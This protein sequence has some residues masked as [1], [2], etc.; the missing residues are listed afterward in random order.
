MYIL[1]RIL[2]VYCT[3]TDAHTHTIYD[4]Y[5]GEKQLWKHHWIFSNASS[6]FAKFRKWLGGRDSWWGHCP[7]LRPP[8]ATALVQHMYSTELG[9]CIRVV[10]LPTFSTSFKICTES[11]YV[12]VFRTSMSTSVMRI[13]NFDNNNQISLY[14]T[15]LSVLSVLSYCW[16]KVNYC[17]K[18][19]LRKMHNVIQW[20]SLL[21]RPP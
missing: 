7:L 18:L 16:K 2:L 10:C 3:H 8:L 13:A 5:G 17:S 20:H 12:R 9:W 1:V 19:L 6:R 14:F 11:V 21:I 4:Q 15:L